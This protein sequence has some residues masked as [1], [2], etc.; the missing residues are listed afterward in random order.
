MKGIAIQDADTKSADNAANIAESE[1]NTSQSIGKNSGYSHVIVDKDGNIISYTL[2]SFGT[3]LAGSKGTLAK[4]YNL[5]WKQGGDSHQLDKVYTAANTASTIDAKSGALQ[6]ATDTASKITVNNSSF[7]INPLALTVTVTGKR[8]YGDTMAQGYTTG[9]T[10]EN[11]K[12]NITVTPATDFANGE[13]A[14]RVLN[15]ENVEKM[16]KSLKMILML[17]ART[18]TV[19][20]AKSASTPMSS[21][22]RVT[23]LP[24]KA[25]DSIR[26]TVRIPAV[27]SHWHLCYQRW[28][29]YADH[30]PVDLTV[31]VKGESIYGNT[32]TTYTVTS[33]GAKNGETMTVDSGTLSNLVANSAAG[34]YTA[35]EWT[36]TTGATTSKATTASGKYLNTAELRSGKKAADGEDT[37]KGIYT[38][39]LKAGENIDGSNLSTFNSNNY[40]ITYRTTQVIKPEKLTITIDGTKV[41]GSQPTSLTTGNMNITSGELATGDSLAGLAIADNMG[42]LTDV[43]TYRHNWSQSAGLN[44]NTISAESYTYDT[45]VGTNQAGNKDVASGSPA[46][47]RT[48][49]HSTSITTMSI[50]SRPMK[51]R[52]VRSSSILRVLRSTE[53]QRLATPIRLRRWTRLVI[54]KK[55]L[56]AIRSSIRRTSR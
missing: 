25:T 32:G 7:K 53:I 33:T 14:D 28:H 11:G 31:N 44:G 49:R 20:L 52:S 45:A 18:A 23:R 5:V 21:A 13:T 12:Y 17:R 3:E 55:A 38:V 8:Y 9:G 15:Q 56:L 27:P 26:R 50:S 48:I 22:V 19:R 47:R 36:D 4:N 1:R 54:Q 51:S 42:Q 40:N 24:S 2:D 16:L 35:N 10:L 43:G 30:N 37:D 46:R 39:Q 29:A 34:S 6:A 41:Y